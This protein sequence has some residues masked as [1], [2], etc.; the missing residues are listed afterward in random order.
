KIER[1]HDYGRKRLPPL[2]AAV[3]IVALDGANHRLDQLLPHVNPHEI[4]RELGTTPYAA[5]QPALTQKRS[6]PRPSPACPWWPYVWS[7][8]TRVRVGDDGKV[9]V[10]PHRLAIAAS[11]RST[12]LPCLRPDGDIFYLRD[13]PDPKAKPIVLLHCPIF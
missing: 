6:V 10:G 5:R 11:P 9:P 13:T 12:V 7:Q 1:H 4:H 3:Q 2:L 8:Q